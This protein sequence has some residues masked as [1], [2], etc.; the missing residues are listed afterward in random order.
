MTTPGFSKWYPKRYDLTLN[1]LDKVVFI[2]FVYDDLKH[3]QKMRMIAHLC[4]N[5]YSL[6][7]NILYKNEQIRYQLGNSSVPFL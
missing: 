7:R 2:F 5:W 3:F 6:A 4:I 1:V